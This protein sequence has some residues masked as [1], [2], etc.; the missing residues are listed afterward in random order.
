[1][2]C[3]CEIYAH[4]QYQLFLNLIIKFNNLINPKKKMEDIDICTHVSG[5]SLSVL[6][7]VKN[8]GP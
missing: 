5:R 1:M 8:M 2:F 4:V 3:N 6:Y 7:E